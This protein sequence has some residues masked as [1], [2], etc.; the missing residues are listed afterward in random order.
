[1]FKGMFLRNVV[2]FI[3]IAGLICGSGLYKTS[4]ADNGSPSLPAGNDANSDLPKEI[5][6]STGIEIVLIPAGEF[7]VSYK[8]NR[9]TKSRQVIITKPFYLGKYPVTQRQWKEIFGSNPSKYT[10]SLDNPVENVSWDDA[11][12]FIRLINKKESTDKYRLPTSAE[13]EYASAGM[14]TGSFWGKDLSQIEKHGWFKRNSVGKTHP[15]GMKLPNK[16]NLYDML[17]NVYE[18]VQDTFDSSMGVDEYDDAPIIVDPV[19]LPANPYHILRGGAWNSE[20]ISYPLIAPPGA[21]PSDGDI[22]IRL[23]LSVD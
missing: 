1:M 17:G 7:T 16:W 2:V 3:A 11:Q 21:V 18:W 20:T 15:V 6:T 9:E 14:L 13:W 12:K 10:D 5:T 23:A 8:V 4:A 19:L 22:G